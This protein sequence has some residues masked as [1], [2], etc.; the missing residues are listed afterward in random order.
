MSVK[1]LENE[2]ALLAKIADGDQHAFTVLF[3]HYKRYVYIS[4]RKLMHSDDLAE[5]VVQDIFLKI[6]LAREQ[7]AE[8]QNFGAYLNRLVRNHS[9]NVL[10]Q[11]AQQAKSTAK[12]MHPLADVDHST[13]EALDHRE[14]T[15]ILN[16]ALKRLSP[17]QRVAYD[18]CHVSGLKYQDAAVQMNIAPET[19]HSHMKE[20]LKKIR[21]HF[22]SNGSVYSL[23][24]V[25]LFK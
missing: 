16:E 9:F 21:N 17:Q 7:L 2:T 22:K 10:R 20:A 15:K 23:L 1:E 6:W 3:H 8:V 14:A 18:L 4:G 25:T 11:L 5:E 19:V 24:I 13:T 12:L